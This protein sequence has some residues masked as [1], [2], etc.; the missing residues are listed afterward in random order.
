MLVIVALLYKMSIGNMKRLSARDSPMS[1]AI[2][3]NSKITVKERCVR[4]A[5]SAIG[6]AKTSNR[7][8][9]NL[10]SVR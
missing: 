1:K 6:E 10:E 7:R 2:Y 5:W 8:W 9:L 3:D 4:P